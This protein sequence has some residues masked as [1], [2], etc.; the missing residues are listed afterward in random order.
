MP[1]FLQEQDQTSQQSPE[2]NKQNL[3]PSI[4][5]VSGV[6]RF[7]VGFFILLV[8]CILLTIFI[9]FQIYK[10]G[11]LRYYFSADPAIGEK[12]FSSQTA[13]IIGKI[14]SKD[15]NNLLIQANNGA[16]G[17]F[18]LNSKF[19]TILLN[20]DNKPEKFNNDFEKIKLNETA[21]FTLVKQK[22]EYYIHGIN[23]L[24]QVTNQYQK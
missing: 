11:S 15:N 9:L 19:Q 10:T 21:L 13:I 1:S 20:S 7:K 3:N 18:K 8:L 2:I 16:K 4:S 5:F 12:I 14:I 17:N 23:Y 22:S 24:S 6:P